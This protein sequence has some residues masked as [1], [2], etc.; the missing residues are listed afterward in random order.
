M[1]IHVGKKGTP[2][3]MEVK[4]EEE[5]EENNKKKVSH[6]KQWVLIL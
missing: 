2:K 4:K 1:L 3:S 6:T 5:E